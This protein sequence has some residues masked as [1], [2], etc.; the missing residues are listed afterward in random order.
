MTTIEVLAARDGIWRPAIRMR[1]DPKDQLHLV[2]QVWP[3]KR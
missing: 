3:P 2:H 1:Y